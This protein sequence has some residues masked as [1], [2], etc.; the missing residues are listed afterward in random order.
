MFLSLPICLYVCVMVL[1]ER[2][3][4]CGYHKI[5][6]RRYCR[7][8]NTHACSSFQCFHCKILDLTLCCMMP[9]IDL[10]KFQKLFLIIYHVSLHPNHHGWWPLVMIPHIK[11]WLFWSDYSTLNHGTPEKQIPVKHLH[12]VLQQM[13]EINYWI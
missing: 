2:Y 11:L 6:N 5:K 7:F 4:M 8:E 9:N 3:R 10:S 13:I 1:K 12:L